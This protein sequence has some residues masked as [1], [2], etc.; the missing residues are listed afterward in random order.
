M[1]PRWLVDKR[2]QICA[3]CEQATECVVRFQLLE[4]APKCPLKRLATREQEVAAKAWPEGAERASGCCDSAEN[5]LS[6]GA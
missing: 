6:G 5:Y 4:D 1:I 2:L 3:Q